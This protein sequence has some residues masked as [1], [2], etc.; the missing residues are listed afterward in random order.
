[1]IPR[2]LAACPG[3]QQQ[4]DEHVAYW[5]GEPAGVYNDISEF[6]TYLIEAHKNGQFEC[7]RAAFDTLERF[8]VDGDAETKEYAVV[9]FVES[10]Q[11]HAS[12]EAFPPEVFLPL[13]K[14]QSLLAW[15]EVD[16]MWIGTSNLAD[17]IRKESRGPQ[18]PE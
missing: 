1:M 11:N 14:P 5:Q 9:G 8:L 12:A 13:L 3:F 17:M 6:V 15:K 7:V 2:L 4:W 10:V 18:L 16:E